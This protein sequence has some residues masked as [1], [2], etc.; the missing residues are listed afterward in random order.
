MGL[1]GVEYVLLLLYGLYVYGGM[2]MDLIFFVGVLVGLWDGD[3]DWELYDCWWVLLIFFL[4]L[5]LVLFLVFLRMFLMLGL[6]FDGEE[7][8]E[9]LYVDCVGL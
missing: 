4:I 8:E 7:E 6:F 1:V 3:V 2:C 5:R 9:E